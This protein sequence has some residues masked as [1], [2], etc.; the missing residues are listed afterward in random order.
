MKVIFLDIDG[1]LNHEEWYKSGRAREAYLATNKTDIKAYN[2]DP[3][4]WKWVQKLIDETCAKIVLSSS[5]RCY[6]LAATIEEYKNTAFKPIIDNI[7]GVT[8]SVMSRNRGEEINRFFDIVNGNITQNLPQAIEWLKQHP[9]ETLSATGEKIEQYVIFDDDTDVTNNQKPH[10]VHIDFWN[11]I[12]EKD[13][14]K[15]KQILKRDMNRSEYNIGQ[16]LYGIPS[17][18]ESAKYHPENQRVFIHNGYVNGDGYGML[19]GWE[20]GE[21]VKSTGLTNFMWGGK[22]RPATDCEIE[23]FMK[24]LMHQTKGIEDRR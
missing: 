4:S 11:G 16:F 15:A 21:L 5:W 20:N 1:V 12:Q 19:I 3:E 23:E 13:Y 14:I 7:V 6:D 10:F 18:E 17:S 24:S 22:V 9:L 8:P 2:F